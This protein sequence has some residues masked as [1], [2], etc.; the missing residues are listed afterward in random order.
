MPHRGDL[1]L[2]G[3]AMVALL[4]GPLL[5]LL[6]RRRWR[7][8]AA[9]R[10]E[11]MR[12]AQLA[13]EEAT[14]A[15]EEAAVLAYSPITAATA[16]GRGPRTAQCAVC[17]SPTTTRCSRCKAVRYCS[18]KCQIIHWRQGHKDECHPPQ[19]DDYYNGQV[20]VSNLMEVKARQPDLHNDNLEIEGKSKKEPIV[21]SPE[22]PSSESNFSSEAFSESEF[23]DTSG[24]ESSSDS[25]T[26]NSSSSCSTT[27]GS[28]KASASEDPSLLH[29]ASMGEPYSKD[30][31]QHM[32]DVTKVAPEF[33]SVTSS[34]HSICCT[35]NFQQ[36]PS[37]SR[38]EKVAHKSGGPFSTSII[39][40]DNCTDAKP[41]EDAGVCQD[42]LV[43]STVAQISGDVGSI[44]SQ[45]S[46]QGNANWLGEKSQM[47]ISSKL[48]NQASPC[49]TISAAEKLSCESAPLEGTVQSDH[50]KLTALGTVASGQRNDVWSLQSR[51]L[52]SQS[53]AS[54]DHASSSGRVHYVSP[55]GS[56]K[57]E[58]APKVR[59][60][61]SENTA[62]PNGSSDFKTSVRKVVQQL[63]SSKVSMHH[64]SAFGSDISRKYKML[65]PYDY[66]VKLYNCDKVE[67]RPFG[68]TNCGNSCYAN[69]VLQSLAFTRPLTAYLL[70]GLHS[71][72]CMFSLCQR[73]EW[74]FTCE[75]ESLL[76]KAKQ[77][78]S[79]LSPTGILS[80]IH[81]IGSHLGH[82]REEDAHEFL[83][84]AID[85]M[86]SVCLKEAGSYAVGPLAEETSLIQLTFGGY[87]RSKIRCMRCWGK[88]ER[89]ERMMDLT[90]EIQGNIGTLEEA[91][92]KFTA[93]EIL[94]GENKYHCNR[95]KSYERAKKKLTVLDA[96]NILTIALK[97]FQVNVH[98]SGKFG[99]LNKAVRFP[100]YLDLAPYMSG[101]NDKSPVY[102]LYA[103]VVH[104]DVMNAAFSGHYVCYVKSTQGKWYKTDDSMVKQVELESVLSKNA[105]MLLYARCSPHAPSLIRNTISQG[106]VKSKKSQCKEAVCSEPIGEK[107]RSNSVISH[108][109]SSVVQHTGEDHP[110]QTTNNH[111]SCEPYN[112]FSER[113]LFP[114]TDSSSDSSS[115]LSCSDEGSWSTESTRYSTST[116][117]Y[118]EYIFGESD[119]YNW[120]SPLRFSEDSNG[121]THS[122]V[123]LRLT[124]EIVSNGHMS[125]RFKSSIL[126][127]NIASS[128]Q[129]DGRRVNAAK[130]WS[131]ASSGR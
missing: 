115:L 94:D 128:Y 24:T 18:G 101:T 19:V 21:T 129:E 70:Q 64:P 11:V 89:H 2:P 27:S 36:R 109:A 20:I 104:L 121:Y 123:N 32:A 86:H 58:N 60:K 130:L 65:F 120:N 108:H 111:F 68:L 41:C 49:Q 83:R 44:N 87:L 85:A 17:Y 106:Q 90:V 80:H 42:A 66:F 71:K 117:E 16:A 51:E 43:D 47:H 55:D 9:R 12:L 79:P 107:A 23:A 59:V 52:K 45:L 1:G 54:A 39:G 95:C 78:Q 38:T 31:T 75:F 25:F 46:Q 76:M 63:K 116:D 29:N 26:E 73:R 99:K 118:S 97:R 127:S 131:R 33:S 5:A 28:E 77:G 48:S 62:V 72:A 88:S 113:S 112:L 8:A 67:L 81:K 114:K 102:R 40:S 4:L 96:P 69:A 61:L 10:E 56:L 50:T 7:L 124:S 57:V 6:L 98:K 3:A 100:E 110:Y 84:H 15:E 22:R 35:S 125:D 14:R 53:S 93:T 119:H 74:C 13:A 82:G 34:V 30:P 105:Y 126:A 37:N 103:V 122:P 91:L 92:R